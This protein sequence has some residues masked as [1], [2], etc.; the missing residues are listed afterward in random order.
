V[1]RWRKLLM[2][3]FI[4]IG[5]RESLCISSSFGFCFGFGCVAKSKVVMACVAGL[6]ACCQTQSGI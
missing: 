5:V 1:E 6:S 3:L 2:L 4:L